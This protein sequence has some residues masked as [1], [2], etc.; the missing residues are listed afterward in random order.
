MDSGAL[1]EVELSTY[2]GRA[3]PLPSPR[4]VHAHG[5]LSLPVGR[6]LD[7]AR[8]EFF[9]RAVRGEF[10]NLLTHQV[11]PQD[12][13]PNTPHLVL[14]SS[15]S[16][17]AV[18]AAQADFQVRFYGDYLDDVARGLEYVD[19]KMQAI[20]AGY[21]A[22]GL[23]PALVGLIATFHF[24]G[25]DFEGL[26]AAEHIQQHLLRTEI[27][28][29]DAIQDAM[30]KVALRVRDSYFVNLQVTNY[31]ERRLER[32][33]FPGMGPIRV[34]P[35]EG[36]VEDIGLELTIDI[37]NNLEARTKREDPVVTEDGIRAVTQ[38]L[39]ETGTTTGPEFA[40]SGRVSVSALAASST[41]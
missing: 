2:T 13:P 16:Q 29:Q 21:E 10:P 34:R 23:P 19:R 18:S 40:E 7:S 27:D 22:A 26:S 30:A 36:T 17:L 1:R 25:E 6:V 20:R 28:T 11:L 12:A 5:V 24:S 9:S 3:M 33:V 38:L 35:W 14:A 15:S 39:R 8:T 31:E 32:P 41:P 37:N 4:F